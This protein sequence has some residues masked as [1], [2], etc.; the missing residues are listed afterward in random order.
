MSSR[1][2]E[3]QRAPIRDP[4]AA[5][6]VA[7]NMVDGFFQQQ[8]TGIMGPGVRRDDDDLKTSRIKSEQP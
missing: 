5:A 1:T 4:Y 6:V 8:T 2:S 7:G 3:R